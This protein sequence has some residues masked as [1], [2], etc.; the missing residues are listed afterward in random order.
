MLKLLIAVDGS[1]HCLRAI[2][3][4]AR[5]AQQTIELQAVLLNVR[6]GPAYYGELPPF[7]HESIEQAQR[8]RQ[9]AVL[10]TALAHPRSCGL[11]PVTAQARQG[12]V[13]AEIVRVSHEHAVDQIAMGSHGRG[14]LGTLLLGSVAQRVLHLADVPVLLVKQGPR[15]RVWG[16]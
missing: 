14:P 9:E 16:T 2:E 11:Q 6:E 8:Q 5:L 1:A 7:D 15:A 12:M 3:A 4:V 10:H 13:A